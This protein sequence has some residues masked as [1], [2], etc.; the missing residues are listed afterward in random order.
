MNLNALLGR[1]NVSALFSG[2][3]RK[4]PNYFAV[5]TEGVGHIPHESIE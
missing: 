5:M 2:I 1:A 3:G 4:G